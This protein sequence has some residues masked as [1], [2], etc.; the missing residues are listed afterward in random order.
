MKSENSDTALDDVWFV[1]DGECPL[2]QMGASLYRIRQS[3]GQ[4]HVVDARTEAEHPV[5]QEINQAEL[6][7]D[8]GMV[9]KYREQ[10]Y[11]GDKAL[12]LMAQLG[13]DSGWLNKVNN[14]LFQFQALSIISY[15]FMR[16]A[17]NI[18]L[19]LKGVGKIRNLEPK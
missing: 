2:C 7:V 3:V 12:H 16:L 13:A 11:Q 15:P 5:M 18:A 14:R 1:Y 4:L 8:A 10:L 19:C 17:R 6:N 9:I